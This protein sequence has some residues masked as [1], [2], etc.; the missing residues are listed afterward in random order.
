M[1]VLDDDEVTFVTNASV[2]L[3][4]SVGS[5]GSVESVTSVGSVT[6]V[7]SVGKV[8][9][10]LSDEVSTSVTGCVLLDVDDAGVVVGNDV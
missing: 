3:V 1:D 4:T 7:A 8:A 5:V 2:G 9:S 6:S 10:E